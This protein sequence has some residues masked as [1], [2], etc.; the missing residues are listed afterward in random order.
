V[1]VSPDY[2]PYEFE[3]PSKTGQDA[4]VGADME[5]ARYIAEQMGMTLEI[6]PMDFDAC[7]AAV[8]QG[9]ADCSISAFYPSE[10]RKLVVDFTDAYFSDA[11]Q[12]IVVSKDQLEKYSTEDAFKGEVVAAQNGSVQA[13]IVTENMADS[14]LQLVSKTSDGIQMVRSG[15]AAGIVLQG[16]MAQAV[17]AG[18]DSLAISPVTYTHDEAELVIAVKK[19]NDDLTNQLNEIIKKVKE[20]KLY[21]QWIVE[22]QELAS[23]ITAE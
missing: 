15:K 17:V 22:A 4:Y 12:D 23:S 21:D 10:E 5:L 6:Q 1:S 18:D 3:D 7:L 11:E 20:E 16:V 2:A 9:K 19:G 8:T 14:T 13:S